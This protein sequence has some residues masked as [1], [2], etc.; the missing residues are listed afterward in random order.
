MSF[1]LKPGHGKADYLLYVDK[2]AVGVVE[3]KPAGTTL[4][5]VEAQSGKY[6]TGLPDTLPAHERPLPFLYESTGEETQFTN[7]LDP[8]NHAAAKCSPFILLRPCCNGSGPMLAH[9]ELALP[10]T[11]QPAG[12]G[13]AI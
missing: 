1:P 3:A 11:L 4:T 8:G 13:A 12:Q 5:G 2:K 10:A 6:S 9:R 7:R